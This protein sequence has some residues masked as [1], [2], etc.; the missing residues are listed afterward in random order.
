MQYQIHWEAQAGVLALE[1]ASTELDFTGSQRDEAENRQGCSSSS[2][3]R[4]VRVCETTPTT[5]TTTTFKTS[6]CS[7]PRTQS[8]TK[9]VGETG[10]SQDG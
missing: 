2:L 5:T 1:A 8:K 6:T 4:G 10:L 3:K 7:R 9:G